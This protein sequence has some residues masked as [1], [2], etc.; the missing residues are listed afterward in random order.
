MNPRQKQNIGLDNR[1]MRGFIDL[2]L[3]VGTDDSSLRQISY[4]TEEL[5]S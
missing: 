3:V 5:T 1:T 2:L 4:V